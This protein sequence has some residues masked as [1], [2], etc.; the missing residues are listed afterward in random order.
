MRVIRNTKIFAFLQGFKE[1]LQGEGFGRTHP[2]DQGW[3]EAYDKGMNFA[4][5]FVD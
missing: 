5:W 3:N 1:R 2:S 4:E